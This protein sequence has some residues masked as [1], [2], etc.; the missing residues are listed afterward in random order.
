MKH[1]VVACTCDENCG[2]FLVE[3]TDH[4]SEGEMYSSLFFRSNAEKRARA[5]AVFM[6]SDQGLS[7]VA[8]NTRA[9]LT[10]TASWVCA[11]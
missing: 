10:G 6:N 1:E 3:A 9:D 8:G 7:S 11:N 2:A 5:Y 4:D